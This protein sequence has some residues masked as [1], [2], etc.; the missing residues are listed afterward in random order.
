MNNLQYNFT[1]QQ[2]TRIYN[3][4]EIPHDARIKREALGVLSSAQMSYQ[5][6]LKRNETLGDLQKRLNK[7]YL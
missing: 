4:L 1:V 6:D 7:E 5:A 3:D 2:A